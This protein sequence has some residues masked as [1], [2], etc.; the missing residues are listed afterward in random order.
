MSHKLLGL[1]RCPGTG[2]DVHFLRNLS[3]CIHSCKLNE[4]RI[5]TRFWTRHQP[6]VVVRH[7]LGLDVHGLKWSPGPGVGVHDLDLDPG[8]TLRGGVVGVSSEPGSR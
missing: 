7:L 2:T 3:T 1:K 8:R 6:A 5:V 4:R